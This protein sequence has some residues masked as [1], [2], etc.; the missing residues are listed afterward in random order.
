MPQP[1]VTLAA[2][3]VRTVYR[4]R[5]PVN[6]RLTLG[7]LGRGPHD[8]TTQWDA[9]GVWRTFRT[10]HGPATL[11][12]TQRGAEIVA[13]AW[14]D[15]AAWA[16]AAVPALLGR[17]DD[18]S[19]LDVNGHPLLRSARHRMPGLRLT[20]T[21]RVLE[22]LLPAIIEQ[23]VTST[24]AYRSWARLVR[25]HGERAPGPAPES[26]RVVPAPG[27]WRLVPSWEWHAAGV[28]P[29]RSRAVVEA[30]VAASALERTTDPVLGA[31]EV[32]RRLRSVRGI[33]VWTAAETMQRSHGDPDA[34][35][36]GDYHLA[37]HVGSALIGQ[38]VDD[39]GMLELLEPWR[40][41]RQRVVRLIL[42]SGFRAERHG[43]R[44]T[45]QDH[46]WH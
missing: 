38:R 4:P 19:T 10:P 37:A 3:G 13:A 11:R 41:H 32:S 8:P 31:E 39:D 33:G 30:C 25:R 12:L 14:G 29:R 21:G 40:G 35:S 6:L 28:D 7:T 18:W 36:V 1:T 17:D 34:V 26:L 20:R 23:K 22:A 44:M 46:R 42:A 5:L 16:I 9:V 15:G 2:N 43:P 24:E 45:I 27:T